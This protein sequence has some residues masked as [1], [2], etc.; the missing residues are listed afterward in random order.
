MIDERSAVLIDL[1]DTLAWVDWPVIREGIEGIVL[2]EYADPRIYPRRAQP[3]Q[4]GG[5][6]PAELRPALRDQQLR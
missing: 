4:P 2:E 6:F 5:A 3:G 1:Y